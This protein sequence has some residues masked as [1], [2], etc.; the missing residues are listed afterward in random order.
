MIELDFL[1]IEDVVCETFLP[2]T[3]I[4]TAICCH[5]TGMEKDPD[6]TFRIDY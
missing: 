1:P 2:W 5:T 3:P 4:A 6:A